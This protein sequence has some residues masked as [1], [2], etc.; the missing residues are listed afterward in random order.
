MWAHPWFAKTLWLPTF[1]IPATGLHVSF[2]SLSFLC[3]LTVKINVCFLL[4]WMYA[5]FC[6]V[7]SACISF[8]LL[9]LGC[10]HK[11]YINTFNLYFWHCDLPLTQIIYYW[12]F[13][14][15]DCCNMLWFGSHYLYMYFFA[16]T[17]CRSHAFL[18]FT[19]KYYRKIGQYSFFTMFNVLCYYFCCSGW[20]KIHLLCL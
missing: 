16:F 18:P 14:L 19:Q 1:L 10:L 12:H 17:S 15:V 3:I 13:C 6:F 5:L 7:C 8:C 20:P 11:I 2:I 4:V 9:H